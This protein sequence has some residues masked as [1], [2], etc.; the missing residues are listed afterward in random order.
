LKEA[1]MKLSAAVRIGAQLHPPAYGDVMQ[2]DEQGMI[3]TDPLG[4]A[5]EAVTGHLPPHTQTPADIA[6]VRSCLH[7]ACGIDW[8]Q[9][10]A[11]PGSDQWGTRESDLWDVITL[12]HDVDGWSREEIASW[13]ERIGC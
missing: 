6:E 12:L 3:Q 9:I 10:V 11:R 13:L 5:Y 2:I 4:A 1:I 7:S 8:D